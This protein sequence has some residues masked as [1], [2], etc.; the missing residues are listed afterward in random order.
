MSLI[1]NNLLGIL[2][3]KRW[4]GLSALCRGSI[5]VGLSDCNLLFL[6]F[7]ERFSRI[8]GITLLGGFIASRFRESK[9]LIEG[10][11]GGDEGKADNDAPNYTS[12][13]EHHP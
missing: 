5:G 12:I 1:L 13:H 2:F 8:D 10:S 6:H 9:T 4:S 11:E 3:C 7:I